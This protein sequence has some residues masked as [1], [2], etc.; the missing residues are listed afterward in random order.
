MALT[1][2]LVGWSSLQLLLSPLDQGRQAVK[3]RWWWLSL[4]ADC[5]SSATP[6]NWLCSCPP[7]KLDLP[8]KPVSSFSGP[9]CHYHL[10]ELIVAAPPSYIPLPLEAA[11][12]FYPG[13]R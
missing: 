3:T 12:H 2:Q 4:P 6:I 11:I 10:I 5:L 1:V 8:S 13:W 7:S 9:F